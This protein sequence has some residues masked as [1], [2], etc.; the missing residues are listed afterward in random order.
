MMGVSPGWSDSDE[1][2]LIFSTFNVPLSTIATA[3][4]LADSCACQISITF[5]TLIQVELILWEKGIVEM[6]I[7]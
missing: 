5:L 7:G 6:R 2:P 4:Y 3:S 1:T